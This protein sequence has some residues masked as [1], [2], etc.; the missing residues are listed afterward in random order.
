MADVE[1]PSA[2]NV[3]PVGLAP[4]R[5]QFTPTTPRRRQASAAMLLAD[6]DEE[7]EVPREDRP[8]TSFASLTNSSPSR[9]VSVG[10]NV[11]RDSWRAHVRKSSRTVSAPLPSFSEIMAKLDVA[12]AAHTSDGNA[13]S[14]HDSA[15]ATVSVLSQDSATT[16]TATAAT[17]SMYSKRL[18]ANAQRASWQTKRM[19][20][21]STASAESHPL[22]Y[23]NSFPS[24]A[25]PPMLSPAANDSRTSILPDLSAEGLDEVSAALLKQVRK[26]HAVIREIVMTEASYADDMRLILDHFASSASSVMTSSQER[27]IFGNVGPVSDFSD[28]FAM[29]LQAA[30]YPVLAIGGGETLEQVQREDGEVRI[31]YFFN[32]YMS[33]LRRVYSNYCSSHE[34]ANAVL[35]KLQSRDE[36][37][38]KW[39]SDQQTEIGDRTSAWDLASLLIKPVQRVLKYPL[40]L[41]SLLQCTPRSHQ[42]YAA[43]Q[44]AHEDMVLTAEN[45]N[46]VKRRRDLVAELAKSGGG[47]RKKSSALPSLDP[48]A[49]AKGLGRR[50][51]KIKE[52]AGL[53]TMADV[54]DSVYEALQKRFQMQQQLLNNLQAEVSE[55]LQAMRESLKFHASYGS[56]FLEVA[57]APALVDRSTYVANRWSEYVT[58]AVSLQQVGVVQLAHDLERDVFQ[59]LSVLQQSYAAPAAVIQERERRVD[60]YVRFATQAE[61]GPVVDKALIAAADQFGHLHATLLLELPTF[62]R[63]T[64]RAMDLVICNLAS[65]QAAWMMQW[66]EALT[67]VL[68]PVVNP[69]QIAAAHRSAN[70]A[71]GHVVSKA[72]VTQVG[73]LIQSSAPSDLTK[74]IL[75]SFRERDFLVQEHAKQLVLINGALKGAF[76]YDGLQP[77]P[78]SQRPR[79]SSETSSLARVETYAS[80]AAGTG[81]GTGTGGYDTPS[82]IG[83]SGR[84][85]SDMLGTQNGNMVGGNLSSVALAREGSRSGL[86][87]GLN[88]PGSPAGSGPGTSAGPSPS[89]A[90]NNVNT[91][92]SQANGNI[93]SANTAQQP[94]PGIF[95]PGGIL[96]PRAMSR[97]GITA[98]PRPR[99][100]H[101]LTSQQR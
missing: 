44:H 28:E 80:G 27:D 54:E 12:D 25:T 76:D 10:T 85:L 42:D 15:S 45:I 34:R 22:R 41:S 30:A 82:S 23:S 88:T 68:P 99:S 52:R 5:R 89:A 56:A 36:Q 55:W 58:A 17:D 66:H 49:L 74:D 16:A 59:P 7:N 33:R 65:I 64:S 60:D 9:T 4:R 61:R 96:R 32:M 47:A 86:S 38:V 40:L 24:L 46:A 62:F 97:A 101:S 83:N 67:G 29:D 1:E 78:G 57:E 31:G 48:S 75:T 11:S 87:N 71:H 19:S 18:S 95:S 39:L 53:E 43:L 90:P 8:R 51:N 50:A 94:S 26:R 72:D 63:V 13:A 93:S 84:K 2:D 20:V 35:A 79:R 3:A 81:S 92:V 69:A 91:S 21:M 77:Q 70:T 100:Q 98:K 73:A 37:V 14:T 6:S